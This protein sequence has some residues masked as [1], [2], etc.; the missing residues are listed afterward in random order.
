MIPGEG[1]KIKMSSQQTLTYPGQIGL[2]SVSTDPITNIAQTTATSGGN[3]T[4]DGGATVTARGVCWNTSGNPTIANDTT[5]DGTGTG[6]FIS[7]LTGL[8]PAT[9]Y[10][11]SAYVINPI[12][13]AYGLEEQFTTS[14]QAPTVTTATVTNISTTTATAGGDITTQGSSSVTSHGVCYGTS[15]NPDTTGLHTSLGSGSGV[16]SSNLSGLSP[17]TLYYVRAYATNSDDTGYGL[18]KQFTTD[19]IPP[20]IS[21]SNVTSINTTSATC[22]GNISSQGSST[23]IVS[24]LCWSTSPNP[25]TAN[26]TTTN[27]SLSG[28]FS[29][30]MSGLSPSTLYYV[31]AYATNSDDTG[32]GL[33]K[34]FTT[35]GIP[36]T[37]STSNVTNVNTTSATSGGNISSQGSSAVIV[38]GLCWSTSPNPTT[39][40]YTTTNGSLSGSFS[41]T[42]SGL[43][44]GTPYYIR[45]YATNSDDT[46]YGSQEQFTTQSSSGTGTLEGYAYYA[47][48]TIPVSGVMVSIDGSSSTTG[49]S[50]YYQISGISTG[51]LLLSATKSGYDNYSTNIQ[52]YSGITPPYN[53]EMTSA[54]FTHNLYGEITDMQNG[55]ALSL[56]TVVVLNPDST[57]SGLQTISDFS[58]NYQVPTVPQGQRLVKFFKSSYQTQEITI[59]MANSNYLFNMQLHSCTPDSVATIGYQNIPYVSS[60]EFTGNIISIGCDSIIE[61]G[62]CWSVNPNP[63]FSDNKTLLGGTDIPGNFTSIATDLIPSTV[64]YVKAYV[65]NS[66]DTMYGDDIQLTTLTAG[67]P[68]PGTS[69][70]SDFDGNVYNTVQIGSQCWMKQN[71][72]VTHYPNGNA[73][74]N[75][76]SVS[77]WSTLGYYGPAYCYYNNDS[78][79]NAETYGALYT[80]TSIMNGASSSNLVPSGIQGICP[81]GWHLPSDEEWKILEGTVDSQYGYPNPEWDTHDHRGY[82]AGLNLKSTTGWLYGGNGTDLYGFSALPSGYRSN[83]GSF[84]DL[85]QLRCNW[86]STQHFS[87]TAR[88]RR[89]TSWI[90]TIEWMALTMGWG[91]S[92]RCLK[93]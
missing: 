60:A 74:P 8:S 38:S 22:G 66:V 21:T 72:R 12:N 4:D 76:T 31:R 2:L 49:T 54:Q 16:F 83:D 48:T 82:D 26:Y 39:A 41:S 80:W 36:P 87:F 25:T 61:H 70:V 19:G 24:G 13:T 20:T 10:Y 79:A 78:A 34:Q 1:Y 9:T 37:I 23:V 47:S 58:G 77:A 51:N 68:C 52:I 84:Y 6:P 93:D 85:G 3:V 7:Y 91:L 14:G 30:T 50:G 18:Q 28:S 69:T 35:D 43:S 46:G 89:I 27:G 33:Q 32:Y 71:L 45:A 64:Y 55:S 17:G 88:G 67:L 29:S 57:P 86:T 42:M 40:N 11:V 15:Q 63:T 62:H 81:I 92:V 53:I 5:I 75:V 90:D 73:I 59:F 44:P 65:I 56:V